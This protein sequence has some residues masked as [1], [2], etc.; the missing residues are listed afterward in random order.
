MFFHAHVLTKQGGL[1]KLRE[2]GKV[3]DPLAD[4]VELDAIYNHIPD[5]ALPMQTP[6]QAWR[7]ARDRSPA[8]MQ[9]LLETCSPPGSRILDLTA[10]TGLHWSPFCN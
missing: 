10:G 6:Q 8:F 5:V 9:V 1:F 4:P 2:S 7:G 3:V